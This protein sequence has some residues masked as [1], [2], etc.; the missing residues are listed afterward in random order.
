M[1]KLVISLLFGL[2][3]FS[4]VQALRGTYT[5]NFPLTENPISEG[6]NWINGKSVG[7]DWS[8]IR[9]TPGLAFGTQSGNGGYDDSMAVLQGVWGPDQSVTAT[10]RT[11]NQNSS[12]SEEV[13]LLLRTSITAH[14]AKGYEV[15]FRCTHDGS[16]YVQLVRWNGPLGNFTYLIN[17]DGIG[18]GLYNG[19]VVKATMIGTV[20][21]A[22]VNGV[23][24]RRY[25]TAGDA[26]KYSSGS[27]GMGFFLRGASSAISDFGFTSFTASDGAK[28]P[29]APTNLRITFSK[30]MPE[31]AGYTASR[32]RA[33][34]TG[35]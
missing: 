1:K 7:L 10:V 11:V 14:S 8:N 33:V 5:T 18:P 30:P 21:T 2:A 29:T 6:S 9:T 16:Q 34:S 25:D 35:Y 3:F 31:F 4:Q 27:P 15:N 24:V 32:A 19:D 23:Q 13:E 22:Y 17:T 20:I 28:S 26:V 12:I